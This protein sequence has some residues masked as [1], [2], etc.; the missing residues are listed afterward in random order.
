MA[1]PEEKTLQETD[2]GTPKT[3]NHSTKST[4]VENHFIQRMTHPLRR[5]ATG[6]GMRT[7]LIA[8]SNT[9]FSPF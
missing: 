7:A 8:S 9:F 1:A 5:R 6:A 2:L 4:I 3:D